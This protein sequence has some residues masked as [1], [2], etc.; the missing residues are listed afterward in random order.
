MP[1]LELPGYEI[2]EWYG[3][4]SVCSSLGSKNCCASPCCPSRPAC[5]CHGF[6]GTCRHDESLQYTVRFVAFVL[7]CVFGLCLVVHVVGAVMPL[8]YGLRCGCF[9]LLCLCRSRW[10]YKGGLRC[11]CVQ[12]AI[13]RAYVM[14]VYNRFGVIIVYYI[15]KHQSI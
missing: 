15:G 1:G 12:K 2:F 7:T 13:Y 4:E 14:P 11:C 3:T 6:L 9:S 5:L 10:V 8:I